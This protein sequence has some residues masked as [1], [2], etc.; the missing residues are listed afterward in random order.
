M[1]TVYCNGGHF[2]VSDN[3]I[4]EAKE[5]AL[6]QNLIYNKNVKRRGYLMT[7]SFC[8]KCHHEVSAKLGRR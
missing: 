7:V 8:N 6:S 5:K 4:V 2:S 3:N 1:V